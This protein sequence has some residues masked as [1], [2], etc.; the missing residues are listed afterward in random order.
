MLKLLEAALEWNAPSTLDE[1]AREGARRMLMEAL[2]AEAG[3]YAERHRALRDDGRA[4]VV[5]DG[6]A[7]PRQVTTDKGTMEVQAPRVHDRRSGHRFTSS[8]LPPHMRR[9]PKMQEVLPDSIRRR[10]LTWLFRVSCGI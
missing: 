2:E 6:R 8:I 5:R 10:S 7:R 1:F 9:P 3:D 4:L